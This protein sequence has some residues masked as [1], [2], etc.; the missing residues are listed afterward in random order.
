MEVITMDTDFAYEYFSQNPDAVDAS[1]RHMPLASA[2][3][4]FYHI[5]IIET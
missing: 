3:M 5:D 1:I 4:K 2:L